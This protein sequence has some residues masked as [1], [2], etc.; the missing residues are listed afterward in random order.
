MK[1]LI[2]KDIYG[3][4]FQIFGGIALMLLP[5]FILMVSGG[6]TGTADVRLNIFVY[7]MVNYV[8]VSLCSSFMLNTLD[9]DEKSGW[10]KMQRAMPVS[11]GQIFAGKLLATCVV[12]GILTGLSLICNVLGAIVFKLPAEPLIIMP[13]IMALL[14]TATLSVC[15][16]QGYRFGSRSTLIVY[17]AA[18]L[19]IAAGAV[20][21]LV[22]LIQE[23]VSLAMLRAI[24]Y[25][26]VPALAAAV[27]VICFISGKKAVARDI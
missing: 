16:A 9:F 6:D 10:T 23:L 13:F 22:G 19:V 2:L 24:A 21:L 12:L 11:D 26:A 4:R 14:Q 8:N 3:V 18:D 17:I 27:I 7:G 1:G 25:G 5:N 20:L 15:F